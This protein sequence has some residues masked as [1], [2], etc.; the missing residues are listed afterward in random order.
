MQLF[1]KKPSPNATLAEL[2]AYYGVKRGGE[3]SGTAR[4]A[5]L[6]TVVVLIGAAIIFG[7]FL[8]GRG[9]YR[10]VTNDDSADIVTTQTEDDKKVDTQKSGSNATNAPA[11]PSTNS[12]N[13]QTH[14]ATTQPSTQSS[15]LPNTGPD[16]DL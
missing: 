4:S 7:L 8:G 6:A 13:S 16:A 9:I 10:A 15:S 5:L 11:T 2:E 1:K 14:T 12:S 3:A